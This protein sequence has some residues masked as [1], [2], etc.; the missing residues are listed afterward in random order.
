MLLPALPDIALNTLSAFAQSRT[1]DYH[2]AV[3]AVP[4]LVLATAWALIGYRA[5]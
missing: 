5:G 2:Y 1:L 4:F 3:I